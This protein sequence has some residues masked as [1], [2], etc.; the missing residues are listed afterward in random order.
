MTANHEMRCHFMGLAMEA[1]KVGGASVRWYTLF[2][3]FLLP[4]NKF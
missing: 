3:S 1:R 4:S 2:Y